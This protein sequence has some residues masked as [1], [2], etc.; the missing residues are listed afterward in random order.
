MSLII[1]MNYGKTALQLQVDT[2]PY[3][4]GGYATGNIAKI[5]S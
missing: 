1:M 5:T 2:F 3:I 4:D